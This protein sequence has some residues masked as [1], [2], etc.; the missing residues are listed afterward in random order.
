MFVVKKIGL[1]PVSGAIKLLD[2]LNSIPGFWDLFKGRE[3]VFS[4]E[5]QGLN[6]YT[7]GT[8]I[9]YFTTFYDTADSKAST[10]QNILIGKLTGNN[11][12]AFSGS[13]YAEVATDA[14][15]QNIGPKVWVLVSDVIVKKEDIKRSVK[16]NAWLWLLPAL[17]FYM[18]ANTSTK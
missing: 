10:G 17:L 6:V 14:K 4:K 11:V 3:I 15:H 5:T 9:T 2:L 12:K 13:Q 7:L 8:T 16:N 18:Q 1:L